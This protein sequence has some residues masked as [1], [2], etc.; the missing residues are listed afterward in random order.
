MQ[1]DKTILPMAG[2]GGGQEKNSILASVCIFQKEKIF[3]RKPL[4]LHTF[5]NIER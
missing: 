1:K 4:K 3:L 2:G 5:V